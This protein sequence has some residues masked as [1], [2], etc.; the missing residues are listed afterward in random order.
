MIKLTIE[1]LFFAWENNYLFEDIS[2]QFNDSEIIQIKGEN[3]VGKTTLL[4]LI[5]GMIPHFNRGKI[6]KGNISLGGKSVIKNSPKIFYP[7]T[8]FIPSTN[9]E[10]FLLTD[11]LDHEIILS[12]SM[13]K[14]NQKTVGKK[15]AEFNRFFAS[16]NEIKEIPFENMAFN[17]KLLALTFVYYLQGAKIYLFDEIL[18]GFS[19]SEIQS[20]YSFFEFLRAQNCSILFIDHHLK[21]NGYTNW[22]LKNKKIEIV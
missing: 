8:A 1:N 6:L 3:G 22:L 14:I 9:I 5:S 10:F 11:C 18:N 2:C 17:Q 12:S 7:A 16:L 4:Q 20:W 19:E 21:S 15:L 13:Q